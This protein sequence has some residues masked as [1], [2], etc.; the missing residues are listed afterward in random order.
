VSPRGRW[1]NTT[2]PRTCRPAARGRK[3]KAPDSRGPSEFRGS[4]LTPLQQAAYDAEAAWRDVPPGTAGSA[5]VYRKA[6]AADRRFR[7]AAADRP[8]ADFNAAKRWARESF[9]EVTPA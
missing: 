5:L 1:L 2:A 7:E 9:N 3:V 8:P 6:E 4:T